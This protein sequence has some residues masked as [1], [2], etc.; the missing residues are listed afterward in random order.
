MVQDRRRLAFEY[1]GNYAPGSGWQ[2]FEAQPLNASKELNGSTTQFSDN[3]VLACQTESLVLFGNLEVTV[4][5]NNRPILLHQTGFLPTQSL[6]Q[7][8]RYGP[9][10]VSLLCRWNT[11]ALVELW[12]KLLFQKGIGCL[13]A[14]YRR[15]TQFFDQ[16]VLK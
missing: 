8:P 11:K 2:L 9:V 10:H 4:L 16:P 14:A 6:F 1:P 12:Q 3:D 7:V 15:Q 13:Q 5:P